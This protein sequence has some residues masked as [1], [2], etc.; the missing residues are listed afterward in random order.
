LKTFTM[1]NA[2]FNRDREAWVSAFI[3]ASPPANEADVAVLRTAANQM[4]TEIG[5]KVQP[6]DAAAA[7]AQEQQR[8]SVNAPDSAPE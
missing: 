8:H 1:N 4:Y 5:R 2:S 7:I 6:T 3:A